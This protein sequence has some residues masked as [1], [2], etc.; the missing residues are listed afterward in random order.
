MGTLMRVVAVVANKGGVGKSTLAFQVA[1]ELSRRGHTVLA[2]DADRQA[3]L[4]RYARG[5]RIAGLGL[6][7]V[8]G[9]PA[10][11]I[12]PRPYI[13][14][15]GERLDLLGSSSQLSTVERLLAQA[16]DGPFLLQ[17]ALAAVA[18]DYDWAVIDTGPAEAL[19]AA[20]I[21]AADALL[22]PTAA[23]SP[24]ADHAG[25]VLELAAQVRG[26][27]GLPYA[28]VLGRSLITVWRR[29]HNGVADARVIEQLRARFRDLVCPTLIPHSSRVSEANAQRLSLRQHA[30]MY[31]SGRDLALRAAVRAYGDVTA[32]L[33]ARMTAPEPVPAAEAVGILGAEEADPAEVAAALR[34][35]KSRRGLDDD[36]LA[37]V[38]GKPVEWVRQTLAFGA[39]HP[40]GEDRLTIRPR[41][42]RTV[43][44]LASPRWRS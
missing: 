9:N 29:Q 25:E 2:V 1:A 44:A 6:D 26:E 27:L 23:S 38:L 39:G 5:P 41:L 40:E 32:F 28:N 20:A 35:L 14:P 34:R 7:A 18:G 10:G 13:G 21:V 24:D 19:V 16:P 17:R 43:A 3:D 33:V 8:L 42:R 11:P 15:V 30:E 36:E 37:E 31:G 4:T 22:M 12:D